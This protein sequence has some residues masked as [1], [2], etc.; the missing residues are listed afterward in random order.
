MEYDG[1]RFFDYR[2]TEEF[3][4]AKQLRNRE[5]IAR[6]FNLQDRIVFKLTLNADEY[7]DKGNKIK[8]RIHHESRYNSF[9]AYDAY[10][11]LEL[12]RYCDE[13]H[14]RLI[15]KSCHCIS[16]SFGLHDCEEMF[17]AHNCQSCKDGDKCVI[18]IVD[19][20]DKDNR[21]GWVMT[22]T[23]RLPKYVPGYQYCGS[24]EVDKPGV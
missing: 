11:T 17:E 12:R 14:L 7:G 21:K 15:G 19:E 23:I 1:T 4:S 6:A 5:E 16:S 20:S 18:L 9:Q 13:G 2:T 8:T 3:K 22:G 10:E 24:I